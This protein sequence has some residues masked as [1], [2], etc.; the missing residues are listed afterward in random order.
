M[1]KIDPE[2][3][4]LISV[5][6]LVVAVSG[7]TSPNTVPQDDIVLDGTDEIRGQWYDGD[8]GEHKEWVFTHNIKSKSGAKYDPVKLQF[9]AYKNGEVVG[10]KNITTDIMDGLTN[11]IVIM[12]VNGEPDTVNMTVLN[13]TRI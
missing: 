13:A 6:V 1:K 10:I 5:L 7:C 4:G 2:I 3:I 11:V 8:Y 12:Q 9:T